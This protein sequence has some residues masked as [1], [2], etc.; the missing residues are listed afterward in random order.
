M[1]GCVLIYL[2]LLDA[3]ARNIKT[4][5]FKATSGLELAYLLNAAT[6]LLDS[7]AAPVATRMTLGKISPQSWP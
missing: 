5:P 1:Y 7:Q 3:C 4:G 2:Q 6:N